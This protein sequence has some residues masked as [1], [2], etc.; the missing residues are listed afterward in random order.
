MSPENHLGA[1]E[2]EEAVDGESRSEVRLHLA[3]CAVCRAHVGRAVKLERVLHA[4][5]RLEPA[6]G[7]AAQIRAAVAGSAAT[8]PLRQHPYAIGIAAAISTLLALTLVYQAGVE[9]QVGGALNFFSFYL[10][11][12]DV[13]MSY[14]G[15]ALA[16]LVEAMPLAQMVMTLAVVVIAFVLTGRFRAAIALTTGSR[17]NHHA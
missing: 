5:P 9:L 10:S 16:A 7:L 15:D 13:L 17:S 14:P 1:L 8:R 2:V 11:Q 12:P 6:P 3:G 4:I